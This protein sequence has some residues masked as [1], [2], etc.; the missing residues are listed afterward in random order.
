MV[1]FGLGTSQARPARSDRVSISV[2]ALAQAQPAYSVLIPNFERV[3]PNITINPT[4]A[5]TTLQY[6]QLTT[7]ELA[8]GNGPD[9]IPTGVGCG[10]TIAVCDL[11]K[12]GYLAPLLREPWVKRSLRIVTSAS[13]YGQGL[14][15]FSPELEFEGL[16]TNDD[17]FKRLGL[18]VP[19]TFQQLL[20]VCT[21]AKADGT[22]P[23]LFPA[24]G[25]TVPEHLVEDIALN[26]VYANDK[27]WNSE[28][29]AGTVSFEG[30]PG[31]HA[32]LQELVDMN[33]A[34]C[35]EPGA[36]GLAS[37]AADA[38]FAQG[39]ALMY[40]NLDSHYGLIGAGD[41]HFTVSHR[42]FPAGDS[43]GQS[44]VQ[45][46][47]ATG[48]AVNAHSSAAN[49][50]AAHLFVDFLA[51]PAQDALYARLIGGFTQYQFLHGQ[52]PTYLTSF[53]SAVA[54]H[55]YGTNP[56]IG[57]WNPDVANALNTESVGLLTGQT[58]IDEVLQAMDAAWKLGRS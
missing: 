12:E 13:K 51:R 44:I 14:F 25:A 18:Q 56:Q 3:Y 23:V 55:E 47:I 6:L 38:E 27:R 39:E 31:W 19:Q 43:P 17:M 52:L 34:G 41:P 53:D 2:I 46:E 11:A 57:W 24:E 30:T 36:A 5:G 37:I 15:V 16:Y 26:T 48:L 33:S 35:F 50:A 1:M 54:N 10:S 9:L 32:A 58:T 49:Q 42:P 28:L 4:Y 22:I 40:F 21:Q 29:N 8:A 20:S 45:L 7:T